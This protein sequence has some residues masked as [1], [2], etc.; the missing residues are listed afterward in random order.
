MGCE[1]HDSAK[2]T[3]EEALSP[4]RES[5]GE[6]L[7]QRLH[8]DSF[9]HLWCGAEQFDELEKRDIVYDVCPGVSAFCGAAGSVLGGGAEYTPPDVSQTVIITRAPGPHSRCRSGE[10]IRRWRPISHHGAVSQHLTDRTAVPSCWRE[11]ILLT[12]GT[13]VYKATLAGGA[14]LPLHGGDAPRD[15]DRQ[16]SDQDLADR[17][18]K[19]SG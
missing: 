8:G 15:G 9:Q 7:R 5:G 13:V 2:L 17:G 12:P 10:S 16:R 19:L 3:L 11:A 4:H 18:G 6:E 1:I 14:Y